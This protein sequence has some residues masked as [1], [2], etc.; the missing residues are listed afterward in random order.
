MMK[1]VDY[2][3]FEVQLPQKNTLGNSMQVSYIFINLCRAAGPQ[4]FTQNLFWNNV[5][6]LPTKFQNIMGHANFASPNLFHS[7]FALT[8]YTWVSQIIFFSSNIQNWSGLRVS[9]Y[10]Y[11]GMWHYFLNLRIRQKITPQYDFL[12]LLLSCHSF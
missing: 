4:G 5:L 7:T 12:Q 11:P 2:D 3:S 1:H 10:L 8:G 9:T 6:R